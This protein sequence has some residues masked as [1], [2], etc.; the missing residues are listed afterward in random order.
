MLVRLK[1]LPVIKCCKFRKNERLLLSKAHF[2]FSTSMLYLYAI[3][4][5]IKNTLSK[6]KNK[7]ESRTS[8]SI[9]MYM[10]KILFYFVAIFVFL[11]CA[12]V[13]KNTNNAEESVQTVAIADSPEELNVDSLAQYFERKGSRVQLK[14]VL[15]YNMGFYVYFQ[16]V[17]GK[18]KNMK[19]FI[20]YEDHDMYRFSVDGERYAYRTDKCKGKGDNKVCW[21][22]YPVKTMD[23]RL[24]RSIITSK[25]ARV[26]FS[27]GT[28]VLITDEQKDALKKTF[29]Y[30]ELLGGQFPPYF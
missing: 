29:D 17:N 13:K 21:Y 20:Q 4:L 27:D 28:S 1:C 16:M 3:V 22:D 6:L 11:S 25:S 26:I 18:A 9:K 24:L 7:K 8:F 15:P 19:L 5:G 12:D 30:F 14:D 23:F 2:A 10:K